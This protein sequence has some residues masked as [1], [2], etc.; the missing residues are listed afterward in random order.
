MDMKST[1][2]RNQS[3]QVRMELRLDGSVLNISH[4]GPDYLILAQP[5]DHPPAR[6]E[7]VM[8]VDGKQSRWAVELPAGVSVDT[9]RTEILP[10]P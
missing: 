2:V 7:I 5:V 8:S 1:G 10:C 4:L 9:Q 3:A 6:A